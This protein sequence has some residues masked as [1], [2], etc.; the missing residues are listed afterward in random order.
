[1]KL[2]KGLGSLDLLLFV[3]IT[4]LR[5]V[6]KTSSVFSSE[7]AIRQF[8]QLIAMD[9]EDFTSLQHD[10]VSVSVGVQYT[11]A[12]WP[13]KVSQSVSQLIQLSGL[14]VPRGNGGIAGLRI[15]SGH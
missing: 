3:I 14:A 9:T 12:T 2:W 15:Y 10:G 11:V 13:G 1:M 8:I 6:F 5:R 4:N 7:T